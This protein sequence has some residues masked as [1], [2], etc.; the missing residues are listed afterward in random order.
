MVYTSFLQCSHPDS[1]YAHRPGY[2]SSLV[3]KV[4][5]PYY[6]D[7]A[8]LHYHRYI[9]LSTSFLPLSAPLASDSDR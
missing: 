5:A 1:I 2:N 8:L 4:V 9:V 3:R 6:L 7:I